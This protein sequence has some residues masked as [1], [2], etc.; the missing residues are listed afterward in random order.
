MLIFKTPN[1]SNKKPILLLIVITIL[2][3]LASLTAF[4]SQ[5]SNFVTINSTISF[6]SQ[7]T[8]TSINSSPSSTISSTSVQST[9]QNSSQIQFSSKE[10]NAPVKTSQLEVTTPS[11]IILPT[12]KIAVIVKTEQV[13]TTPS[14]IAQNQSISPSKELTTFNEGKTISN[15]NNASANFTATVPVKNPQPTVIQERH[16]IEIDGS[17][18]TPQAEG[19]TAR[20]GPGI[21]TVTAEAPTTPL[22]KSPCTICP[23][24][25][26]D[27]TP[28]PAGAIRTGGGGCCR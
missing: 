6:S 4:A 3:T 17:L 7:S 5:N 11:L 19:K 22:P 12:S 16:T 14:L 21:S 1:L 20:T 8:V 9:F 26:Q 10:F 13:P 18:M 2:A 24:D 28:P 27:D 25:S 15:N 23:L